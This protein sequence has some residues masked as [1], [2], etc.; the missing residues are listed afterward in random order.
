ML[1][2]TVEWNLVRLPASI[3]T[4]NTRPL[5]LN[6][7]AF[8][9]S[10]AEDDAAYDEIVNSINV[11]VNANVIGDEDSDIVEG[12]LWKEMRENKKFI[13]ATNFAEHLV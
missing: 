1:P 9:S 2:R 12:M 6:W 4:S 3:T 11:N 5:N 13:E 10:I 8:M 7:S